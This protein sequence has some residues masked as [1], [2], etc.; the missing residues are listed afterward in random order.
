MSVVRSQNAVQI[1]DPGP[2]EA[3]IRETLISPGS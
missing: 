2:L 3:I 1:A